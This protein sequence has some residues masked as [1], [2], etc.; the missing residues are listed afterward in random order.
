[1]KIFQ[2]SFSFMRN[3]SHEGRKAQ[4]RRAEF[5]S[6]KGP[7]TAATALVR[8]FRLT[9]ILLCIFL[10][11]ARWKEEFFI[12][13]KIIFLSIDDKRPKVYISMRKLNRSGRTQGDKHEKA[14]SSII[15]FYTCSLLCILQWRSGN[16]N[17]NNHNYHYSYSSS[18]S[19]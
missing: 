14:R 17:Y 13:V 10:G 12:I 6:K 15:T 1:M 5:P 8:R 16:S 7:P 3:V 9:G 19:C 4:E 11:G 2:L 18:C